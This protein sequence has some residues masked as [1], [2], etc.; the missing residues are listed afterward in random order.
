[1][2]TI[3]QTRRR[4]AAA[5]LLVAGAIGAASTG[6]SAVAA[7]AW[8]IE[9]Y[10]DCIT[11]L[12]RDG[13]LSRSDQEGCCLLSG[14]N[15]V[16]GDFGYGYCV[17]PPAESSGETTPPRD[18]SSRLPVDNLPVNPGPQTPPESVVPTVAVQPPIIGLG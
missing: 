18:P 11:A 15:W 13:E 3:S 12:A 5:T 6:F 7:A 8:D 9:E 17:A 10:D 14:G 4:L 2:N 1:M 16:A